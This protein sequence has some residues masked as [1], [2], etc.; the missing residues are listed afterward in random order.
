L[1]PTGPGLLGELFFNEV[2]IISQLKDFLMNYNYTGKNDVIFYN[3]NII[4]KNYDEY[5]KEQNSNQNNKHYH[6]L[7]NERKIYN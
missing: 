4:L 2:H 6:T 3:N 1:Y 5:R 7:W